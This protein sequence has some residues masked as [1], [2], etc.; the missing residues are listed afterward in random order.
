MAS[1]KVPAQ[2][3][4]SHVL[5]LEQIEEGFRLAAD[6]SRGATKVIIRPGAAA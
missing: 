2:D 5:P 6:K 3:L 4:V 1:R